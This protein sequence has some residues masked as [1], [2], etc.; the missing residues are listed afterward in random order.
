MT[1]LTLPAGMQNAVQEQFLKK[2]YEEALLG[3]AA[4]AATATPEPVDV[5]EGQTRTLTRLAELAPATGP[6]STPTTT[7]GT[8]TL[9][10]I[11]ADNFTNEQYTV[12]P[13]YWAR[14]MDVNTVQEQAMIYRET[15]EVGGKQGRQAKFSR[16]NDAAGAYL[17]SYL[18]GNTRV[19][20][21]TSGP[22]TTQCQVD[23]IRGFQEI[24]QNGT[25][26]PVGSGNPILAAEFPTASGGVSNS[27][28][29]TAA[30]PDGTNVSTAPR[31]ISGVLTFTAVGSAPVVGD[32]IKA[33]NAPLVLRPNGKLGTHLL[34]PGDTPNM[35]LV[36]RATAYLR[37]QGIPGVI[38]KDF[39]LISD[40]STVEELFADP[41]FMLAGMGRFDTVE[42]A[43]ST[44]N[45]YAGCAFTTSNYVPVQQPGG[46]VGVTVR[47]ALIV[48]KDALLRCDFKGLEAW[49]N[50][51]GKEGWLIHN[52]MMVD[53]I[54]HIIRP[55]LDRPGQ[56]VS[57]TW[58]G[59][60]DHVCPSDAGTTPN[61]FP[62]A[63]NALFKRGVWLEF[64]G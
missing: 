8:T 29:V 9:D 2:E 5:R 59:I 48:G 44:I 22:S 20:N 52:I 11:P 17:D 7:S 41:S 46:G 43:R 49:A 27:L 62:T 3:E 61:I 37:D 38:G 64:A 25:Q 28:I 36:R 30:T 6:I 13:G 55:A 45:R 35:Q 18:S 53:G 21:T 10:G 34:T 56:S 14:T 54:A 58:N 23:D 26:T 47:R 15:L 24:L 63:S 57:F 19:I 40:N 51:G 12:A 60:F 32:V 39:L 16:E 1:F 50:A 42:F 31:G 4:F 33:N